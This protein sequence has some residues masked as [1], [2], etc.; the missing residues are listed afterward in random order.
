MGGWQG[1]RWSSRPDPNRVARAIECLKEAAHQSHSV[2]QLRLGDLFLLLRE[3]GDS[4][5]MNRG[6]RVVPKVGFPTQHRSP[7]KVGHA[8]TRTG[9]F[10]QE[11]RIQGVSG[12][13]NTTKQREWLLK[14]AEQG[15]A[16]AQAELAG[17]YYD[18]LGVPRDDTLAAI[19]I[20]R[21]CNQG[22]GWQHCERTGWIGC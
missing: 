13:S 11:T 3:R 12:Y 5:K 4:K 16:G 22:D 20:G 7:T 1:Q 10:T 2:A 17:M 6:D 8:C 14:A 9:I 19:W 21:A 15:D 18:G